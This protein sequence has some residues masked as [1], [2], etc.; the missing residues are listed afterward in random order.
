MPAASTDGASGAG[1]AALGVHSTFVL[2]ATSRTFVCQ[3]QDCFAALAKHLSAAVEFSGQ[4][5]A[6]R[7]LARALER[8]GGLLHE[9]GVKRELSAALGKVVPGVLQL[10]Q[11][12]IA[13]ADRVQALPQALMF[14]SSALTV[15]PASF[16]QHKT[17]EGNLK[18]VLVSQ[19]CTAQAKVLAGRCLGKLPGCMGTAQAWSEMCHASLCSAHTLLDCALMGMETPDG[20]IHDRAFISQNTVPLFPLAT[21]GQV[22]SA[23]DLGLAVQQLAA[24]LSCLQQLL[25]HHM[26]L[27]VPVPARALL[28][29]ACRMLAFQGSVSQQGKK[30]LAALISQLLKRAAVTQHDGDQ[31]QADASL[32]VYETAGQLL[33]AGGI[34]VAG[35]L[36]PAVLECV[37][38]E[39]Y[40]Q[41]P[42]SQQASPPGQKLSGKKRKKRAADDIPTL[43]L[44]MAA[45]DSIPSPSAQLASLARQA[46]VLQLLQ[47]LLMVGGYITVQTGLAC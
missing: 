37:L 4:I 16:K 40:D 3:L 28:G 13:D 15:L 43:G 7:V 6:L 35:M 32:Q 30:Q 20:L 11:A 12:A 34:G 14:L 47:R 44:A 27:A 36:A 31:P 33:T 26:A 8:A 9:A 17:L 41:S 1:S 23:Q 2:S 19:H 18:Q 38:R 22:H 39:V 45:L 42:V 46:A 24:T 29:L 10:V 25:T 21:E 5:G